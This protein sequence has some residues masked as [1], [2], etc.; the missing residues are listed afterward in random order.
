MS[1]ELFHVGDIFALV[2]HLEKYVINMVCVAPFDKILEHFLNIFQH[3][4]P[5]S[6]EPQQVMIIKLF[7]RV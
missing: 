1:I 4:F 6:T 3:K 5:C 7:Q 2:M